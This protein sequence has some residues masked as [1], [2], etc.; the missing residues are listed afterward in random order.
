MSKLIKKL[1]KLV[2]FNEDDLIDQYMDTTE[3]QKPKVRKN[4]VGLEIE[5]LSPQMDDSRRHIQKTILEL[6]LEKYAYIQGDP[7]I[8]GEGRGHEIKLLI[9]ENELLKVLNKF[10]KVIK[11]HKLFVNT[12][13][14]LHVHLDMRNRDYRTCLSRLNMMKH[15]LFS[16]VDK[17]R[18]TNDYCKWES[19][20]MAPCNIRSDRHLAV[21]D[22]SYNKHK[23]IEVRL[24]QG[25]VNV[26]EIYKW[27]KL[28]L[29]ILKTKDKPKSFKK[30]DVL[31]WKGLKP[32][33]KSYV[34]A[35]FKE[36][37]KQSFNRQQRKLQL[38][39]LIY[40]ANNIPEDY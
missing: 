32:D 14:G 10:K 9:P 3:Q 26:D 29:N 17:K 1:T 21:N 6:D 22:L 30:K 8:Y 34:D 2:K 33:L 18:W 25:S 23:T 7:S 27:V 16:L 12:S 19:T 28:L 5:C 36:G 24:H 13:C 38:R 20:N 35:N 4:F 40:Q 15:L 11:K 39:R 31:N 37:W